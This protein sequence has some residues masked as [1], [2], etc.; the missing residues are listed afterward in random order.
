[1][2]NLLPF[3][4]GVIGDAFACYEVVPFGLVEADFVDYAMLQFKKRFE[5]LE[6]AKGAS[7]DE[8]NRVAREMEAA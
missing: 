5:R 6:K 7:L 1:M 3:A 2:N 4:I 8:I